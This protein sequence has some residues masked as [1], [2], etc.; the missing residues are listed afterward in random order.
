MNEP[1]AAEL[2]ALREIDLTT[3]AELASD[4]SLFD[5]YHPRME[6]V[7]RVNAA[8]LREIIAEHGWPSTPLVGAR[9]AEAAFLI[10]QHAIGEPLFM[11]RCRELLAAAVAAGAAPAWQ[12]AYLEDRINTFEDRPQRYGTQLRPA[13][14]G[15]LEP[16]ALA[17]P[18]NVEQLRRDIGLP[19]LADIL[20]KAQPDPSRPGDPAAKAAAELEWRRKV[21]WLIR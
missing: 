17:E 15:R 9:G 21:G 14:D 12:L 6:A 1:L 18:E 5:G 13:A 19:P 10:A 20:A 11:H 3:R 8:R 4:G 7:H 16:C 2:V